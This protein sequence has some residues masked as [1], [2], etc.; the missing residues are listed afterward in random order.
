MPEVLPGCVQPGVCGAGWV[1]ASNHPAP[2]PLDQPHVWRESPNPP[3]LTSLPV[4][5]LSGFSLC[6]ILVAQG[7]GLLLLLDHTAFRLALHDLSAGIEPAPCDQ[8]ASARYRHLVVNPAKTAGACGAGR[9]CT[10]QRV[11]PVSPCPIFSPHVPV[12]PGCPLS[13]QLPHT[14]EVPNSMGLTTGALTR[15]A[16]GGA[17]GRR[18]R[19][20]AVLTD[21]P[22]SAARLPL[23]DVFR[24]LPA[25]FFP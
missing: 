17:G 24:F 3:C 8:A 21:D 13:F 11:V 20:C 9:T 14:L 23:S 16:A 4:Q 19:T 5:T 2:W 25:P 7:E 12:F 22:I 18:T 10:V 1:R 6:R 15:R